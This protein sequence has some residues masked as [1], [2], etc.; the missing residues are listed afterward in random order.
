MRESLGTGYT[1]IA[2][3][4]SGGAGVG[5]A[6]VRGG[7]VTRLEALAAG[8]PDAEGLRFRMKPALRF[9]VHKFCEESGVL[10]SQSEGVGPERV[11]VVTKPF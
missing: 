1:V 6:E 9:A 2:G 10:A 4:D 11:V 3:D 8:S 7:R 5:R